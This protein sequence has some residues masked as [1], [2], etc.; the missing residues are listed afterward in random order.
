MKLLWVIPQ[1]RSVWILF[2]LCLQSLVWT[3][4]KWLLSLIHVFVGH[5]LN[6]LPA[7]WSHSSLSVLK[8]SVLTHQVINSCLILPVELFFHN[9][10]WMGSCNLW[11]I[12]WFSFFILSFIHDG[13][14]S[15][16][17]RWAFQVK[18]SYDIRIILF[19]TIQ[20]RLNPLL[21][22]LYIRVIEPGF[23]QPFRSGY[24]RA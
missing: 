21:L 13:V 8:L 3:W 23:P 2:W 12:L 19:D 4:T 22:S 11:Q 15:I 17:H 6:R 16:E 10:L 1:Q 9:L 18:L 5:K 14:L 7:G 20:T 24:G